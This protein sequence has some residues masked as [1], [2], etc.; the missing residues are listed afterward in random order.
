M[1][2]ARAIA[3]RV[4]HHRGHSPH[5]HGLGARL[6][7][8]V[9]VLAVT[10]LA[11]GTGAVV[12]VG[13]ASGASPVSQATAQ[14]LNV[15]LLNVV[16]ASASD[17]P[18]SASNDGTGSNT[19]VS[20]TPAVPAL[21][22]LTALDVG[23]LAEEA[24]A[25]QNGSSFSCAGV[26]QPGGTVQIGSGN[27]NCTATGGTGGGVTLDLG[28]LPGVGSVLSAVADVTLNLNS[29]TAFASQNGSSAP[30][31]HA[32]FT[33][34]TVTVTLLSGLLPV[35]TIPLTIGSGVDANLLT[36]IANAISGNN[37]LLGGVA[38]VISGALSNVLDLQTNFQP[39]AVDGTSSVTALH[40]G[41]LGVAGASA[42]T[43]DL[44]TAAVGPNVEPVP[45]VATNNVPA[46]ATNKLSS[47]SGPITGGT[48]VTIT[49]SGFTGA[50]AVDFGNTPAT[51]FTVGSSTQITAISPAHTTG[52]VPVTVVGPAGTSNGETFTYC[53]APTIATINGLNPTSGPVAGGTTVTID[54]A[55]FTGATAVDFGTTP[56]TTFTV[57]NDTSI[58]AISPPQAAGGVPVTVTNPGGTCNGE[59]YTYVA[60]P[61]I[62][63]NGINPN[64]GPTAG[65][66]IVTITGTGFAGPATV[67]FGTTPAT[68]VTVVSPTEITATDPAGT[69]G[70]TN[71]TVTDTG[72]TSS[73]VAFTYVAAPTIATT[74]GINPDTGP[75]A[76]DTNVTITGTNFVAGSTVSFGGVATTG[77]TVVSATEITAVAPAGTAG[78]VTVTVT[79]PGGISNPVTYTYAVALNSI[80]STSG[81][82]LANNSVT[83]DG[84]G[85]TADGNATT[86]MFGTQAA[87]NFT[88]VS[89]TQITAIVP[90]AAAGPVNVTVVT[91]IGTSN[92]QTYTYVAGP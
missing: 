42:S 51:G 40:V 44:A 91:L 1:R 6:R 70:A 43:I 17:P 13:S 88:V 57:N 46:T 62:S 8:P 72:G 77:V 14:A 4:L 79:T 29:L 61:T 50:T 36:T 49:G 48:T 60:V 84:S 64:S 18:T 7:R 58:T 90:A 9:A 76:G 27:A 87:V 85:F 92:P 23:A 63:A 68:G 15:N 30:T 28:S 41:L 10:A 2:R 80:S 53:A 66:N 3:E 89:D 47:T 37:I 25:N 69:A 78:P 20:V 32:N 31:L 74:N 67:D 21:S 19:P 11:V 73:P 55:G 59:T 81:P 35:V 82:A 52:G 71:V 38:D 86:V 16:Q 26:V 34:G 22:G 33:G 83:V 12:S 45:A 24:E 54:G 65:G 39:A 75:T 5:P 56:A